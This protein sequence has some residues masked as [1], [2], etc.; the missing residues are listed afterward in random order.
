MPDKGLALQIV[1]R[2]TKAIAMKIVHGCRLSYAE[3]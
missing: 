1:V 3:T 2:G